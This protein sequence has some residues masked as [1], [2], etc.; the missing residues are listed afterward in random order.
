M[1]STDLTILDDQTFWTERQVAAL[2]QLGVD[3]ATNADLA[4]FF[5]Q[6]VRTGLDPFARQIYMI[7]RNSFDQRTNRWVT[8]QTIQT[9]ID[10][11]RLIARRAADRGGVPYSI[12]D[13]TWCGTDGI[14]HDVWLGEGQP[15]AAKVTVYRNGQAFPAVAL[16]SEY[17][18]TKKDG[19]LTSMWL[20]G[21][22]MLGKCVE[23]LALRKAFPQD[24]SGLYTGD[25]IAAEEPP[26]I[27]N[28][29][30]PKRG[31]VAGLRDAV[32]PKDEPVDAD[33]VTED[34]PQTGDAAE[35][36]TAGSEAGVPSPPLPA[37]SP[38]QGSGKLTSDLIPPAGK[39]MKALHAALNEQGLGERDAGLEYL[40]EVVGRTLTT[41]KELTVAEASRCINLL[42]E[43]N[44]H[45][46]PEP[47]EE[48]T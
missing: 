6:S 8:K 40:S 38:D 14:W 25:E 23:A 45:P 19:G 16:F 47:P 42:N 18:G 31:G 35:P 1:T 29:H 15:S 30:A 34:P 43:V 26:A 46:F 4:V 11:F 22:M 24:L 48:P 37:A 5:H 13:I 9:G 33:I 27:E 21:A 36:A 3:G 10:G 17:A 28:G 44:Q 39:Q 41:S 32:A 2:T 12:S 7:G 20:K